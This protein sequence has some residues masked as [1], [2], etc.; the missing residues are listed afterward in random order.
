MTSNDE[1]NQMECE[2]DLNYQTNNSDDSRWP[3]SDFTELLNTMPY[4]NY[5]Q[6]LNSNCSD[7]SNSNRLALA[8]NKCIIILNL[9]LDWPSLISNS[10]P[11]KFFNLNNTTCGTKQLNQPI[12]LDSWIR[13]LNETRN[14]SIYIN[15]IRNINQSE[16]IHQLYKKFY[17]L[18]ENQLNKR[19]SFNRQLKD[20]ISKNKS[21]CIEE[22][23]LVQNNDASPSK[24]SRRSKT[25]QAGLATNREND[26][27]KFI[28]QNKEQYLNKKTN[29]EQSKIYD[30]YY[31]EYLSYLNPYL[32]QNQSLIDSYKYLKWCP[33]NN[34]H[35]LAAIT[36]TNQLII[37]D[38]T[39]LQ[40]NNQTNI[41][42]K[43]NEENCEYISIFD[44][45]TK[46]V[47]INLTELWMI[48]HFKYSNPFKT[49]EEFIL[50]INRMIPTSLCWSSSTID[51]K[52]FQFDLIFVS[53][54]SN[55]IGAFLIYK[56]DENKINLR[57]IDSFNMKTILE[58]EKE[59][60][61]ELVELNL[62]KSDLPQ[63]QINSLSLKLDD[64]NECGLLSIGLSNGN[65]FVI[66]LEIERDKFLNLRN[67]ASK[68]ELKLFQF[69]P[70]KLKRVGCFGNVEKIEL[71]N[72]N[73]EDYL[74]II[75]KENRLLFSIFN[76]NKL[77]QNEMVLNYQTN[78]KNHLNYNNN[79]PGFKN[80]LTKTFYKLIDFI[81]IK[82]QNKSEFEFLLTFE[83]S[84]IEYLNVV[85]E[86]GKLKINKKSLIN[87]TN[88]IKFNTFE[89][90]EARLIKKENSSQVLD[91]SPMS[92]KQS[93]N[94]LFKKTKKIFISSNKQI[95]FQINDF[96]KAI[97][98]QKKP[99]DFHIN[100]YRIRS[101]NNLIDDYLN[102]SFHVN[103]DLLQLNDYIWLFK[104]HLYLNHDLI[105]NQRSFNTFYSHLKS[106]N[107]LNTS[108]NASDESKSNLKRLRILCHYIE[109]YYQI[110]SSFN[111][112]MQNKNKTDESES[113]SDE[114]DEIED[115]EQSSQN[116]KAAIEILP[117]EDTIIKSSSYYKSMFRE[118][119]IN[120]FK[121][122]SLNLISTTYVIGFNKL[123]NYERLILLVM[124]EFSINKNFFENFDIE[125]YAKKSPNKKSQKLD[126]MEIEKWLKT[127]LTVI[128]P[129]KKT[130]KLDDNE[131]NQS[132]ADLVK[133]LKCNFC[134]K[135]LNIHKSND[136]DKI[137]CEDGH[138]ISRCQLTL[139]PLNFIK[140]NKC[141]LCKST[142]NDIDSKDCPNIQ[143]LIPKQ[144]HCLFCS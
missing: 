63:I 107:N 12:Q 29:F 45:K 141:E 16:N 36:T 4:T 125:I 106:Y 31:Y 62:F 74:I 73:S 120:L 15:V 122:H 99:P 53:F 84:F 27:N 93:A 117:S 80:Y 87:D 83:N 35:L 11:F 138:S 88:E 68:N 142:W 60:E 129:N 10:S 114:S 8:T 54:K 51:Y 40:I 34:L 19:K 123:T 75:Q 131:S 137:V 115:D 18:E 139:L 20:V 48:K 118:L 94:D 65:V 14:E 82:N 7:L 32:N 3:I 30:S 90:I 113:D 44:L 86:N 104:R 24:I 134:P 116:S 95:L 124:G 109:S 96:S 91:S 41:L 17:D 136:L 112:V 59:D 26:I 25:T 70:I 46:S 143:K 121:H 76:V 110:S 2:Y 72:F 98:V 64:S 22:E 21:L 77:K 56:D 28:E 55:E 58:D 126:G 133:G 130:I 38:C 37:F 50:N 47:S 119:T 111:R 79:S 135:N 132:L 33:N 81:S 23:Q 49:Y 9:N 128:T 5:G 13:D 42:E 6:F 108:T 140:Y 78:E 105:F 67:E 101:L 43:N 97:L 39:K 144:N 92:L 1:T 57:L 102:S 71:I 127:N 89:V 85:L 52:N 61:D 66:K 69:N 100:I 103:R